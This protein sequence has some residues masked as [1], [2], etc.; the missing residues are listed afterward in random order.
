MFREAFEDKGALSNRLIT[1]DLDTTLEEGL[2][3]EGL[4]REVVNRIQKYRKD[5][6]LNVADRI[7]VE[8]SGDGEILK[9]IEA[10]REYISGE[11]LAIGLQIQ[12][13]LKDGMDFELEDKSLKIK[14]SP[15][16]TAN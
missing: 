1:I 13:E 5:L 16:K 11:V 7:Q 15:A 4:A 14:I 2:L 8:V 10:H 6:D 12:A 9:A 3:Q